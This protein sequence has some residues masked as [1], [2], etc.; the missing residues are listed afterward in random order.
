MI[1]MPSAIKP[2]KKLLKSGK[3]IEVS[4][5]VQRWQAWKKKHNWRYDTRRRRKH[6]KPLN[7]FSEKLSENDSIP[8]WDILKK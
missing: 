4:G 7:P 3:V 6:I 2:C 8:D 1:Q 5:E